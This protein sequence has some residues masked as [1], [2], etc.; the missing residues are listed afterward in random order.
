MPS[1]LRPAPARASTPLPGSFTLTEDHATQEFDGGTVLLGGSPLRLFRISERAR[2]LVARWRTGAPVGPRR[3]A[4]LLAR[5]LVSAGAFAPVPADATF[6]A[7]DVTVVVPVRDRPAQLD[8]LLGALEGLACIVVDDASVDAGAVK[9]IAERHGARFVGLTTNV[10][11][12]AARNAGLADVHTSL[13][14]F[15]DSDCVPTVGWLGPLLGHFDDPLVAAVAPRI[16]QEPGRGGDGRPAV[17]PRSSLDRGPAPGLVRS[18]SRIPFVPSAA[19]LVRVHAVDGPD[20]FDPALRGGEDVDLVWRLGGAGWDVLY[21]PSSTVTHEGPATLGAFLARR[22]FYGTTAAP[23]SRRHG[24]ALAPVHLSGWSL[25][26]W[27]CILARRPVL[28]LAALAASIGIL[29]RR[30]RGLV[31]DPVG[32][33]AHIAGGG[34][35]RAA[36]PALG[37]LTRTWAPALVL[38][39]AF[40]RTRGASALALLLPAL[41][42]WP[43][44]RDAP[45]PVRAVAL[46]IADDIAYGTGVW[47]GCARERTV[48]P[49]IPLISWRARVWSSPALHRDLRRMPADKA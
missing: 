11:P 16:E 13:V 8:R 14:A 25:A 22:A 31:R 24:N 41:G 26:V 18:G 34:T 48:V 30:L 42:E 20:L 33:A 38:G 19:L 45:D 6:G 36:L 17:L 10:G 37:S 40:R 46:H 35:M 3:P 2:Q 32:V 39:L 27:T 9:G 21:E 47:V 1:E 23:L 44:D 28:A 5:R 29:A 43:A 12:A 15:V 4:Q 7:A 49:L